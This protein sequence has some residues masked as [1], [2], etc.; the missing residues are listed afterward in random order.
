MVAFSLFS[1]TFICTVY[2]APKHFK[3][4]KMYVLEET[5]LW[6]AAKKSFIELEYIK[7]K[8]VRRQYENTSYSISEI[9]QLRVG[10]LPAGTASQIHKPEFM[11]SLSTRIWQ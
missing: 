7:D 6:F 3:F 8:K 1:I 2:I 4:V 10:S 5:I 11:N 9:Y